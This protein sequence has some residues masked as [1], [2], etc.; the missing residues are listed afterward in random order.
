MDV[1]SIIEDYFTD[2][3]N[4]PFSIESPFVKLNFHNVYS[5]KNLFIQLIF[6]HPLQESKVNKF[7]VV[8]LTIEK[9]K[10]VIVM[11]GTIEVLPTASFMTQ[12]LAHAYHWE[13]IENA[14]QKI[15][16]IIEN[17]PK[18]RFHFVTGD[19]T[20]KIENK[21]RDFCREV[22]GALKAMENA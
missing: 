4:L 11:S 19:Y 16:H 17:H 1:L 8:R 3:S 22:K 18:C 7:Y 20:F 15:K 5:I 12:M 14:L 2:S 9:K 21:S 13:V 10:N 6:E